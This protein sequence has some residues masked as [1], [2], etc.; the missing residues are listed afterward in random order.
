[1]SGSADA[2]ILVTWRQSPLAAKALL[3]G[4]LVNRLGAFVQIFLV[5]FL[6]FRGFT[7]VQAGVALGV[8]SVGSVAGSLV[9]GELSDRLG[10][11]RTIL[12]SMAGT[13]GMV[14]AVLYLHS[15]PAMLA[16]VALVGAMTATYRP[17]AKSLL[18]ELTPAH[19][20]VMIFAMYRLAYNLST[21]AAPLIGAAL[22][23]VSYDLLFWAE[24]VACL[25]FAVIAGIALPRRGATATGAPAT[26]AEGSYLV[27][28][29]D[30]R[31]VL[32][33]LALLTNAAV[34]TQ[35]LSALPVAMRSQGLSTAW[36]SAMLALNGF[37]VITC[38]LLVTKVVQT[39]P[40]R[41]TVAVGFV[42][43][44]GG[45]ACYTLPIGAAAFVLGTLVWSLAEVVAGPTMFAYSAVASPERHRGRY[46]GA[47][48]AVFGVGSAIG[49]VVGLALW[50]RVHAGV[51]W[52]YAA[53]TLGGIAAGWFGMRAPGPT[54]PPDPAHGTPADAP[55]DERTQTP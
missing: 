1:M 18:S 12:V 40:M 9:G 20:Q 34:Y 15:Y 31:Y 54:D 36:F 45:L 55:L 46:I 43:L 6:T 13:A 50:E 32:F 17:A 28:L 10:P 2:G 21:T 8:Y 19:R 25:A 11:R 33:L 5:L 42:L 41:I 29:R 14:L 4:I 52:W 47:A 3:V 16:A 39:W 44:G 53:A 22:V 51:W 30:G 24:A 23:A 48:S 7:T 27:V 26:A 37:I 38:E 35:Y 49:P